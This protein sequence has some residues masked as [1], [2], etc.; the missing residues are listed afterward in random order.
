MTQAPSTARL[1]ERAG[2]WVG[3]LLFAGLLLCPVPGGMSSPAWRLS[4]VTVLMAVLWLTE[5]VPMAVT[6]LVPL[7]AFP[8]LGIQSSAVVSRGY[9]DQNV[10]L[11]MGGFIIALGIEKC[12]L[13]RR[14]ALRIVQFVGCGLRQ[15]VL[16][17]MLATGFLSMWISNTASTMLMFP[18]ALALAAAVGEMLEH[19][20]AGQTPGIEAAAN[21]PVLPE[22]RLRTLS[23]ALLL[24]IAYSASL[25]GLATTVGTPTNIAM[26]GIW[27]KQPELVAQYGGF[28]MGTWLVTFL[29]LAVLMTLTA[30]LV[31]TRGLSEPQ[32]ARK[33][34]NAFFAQRLAEL[35]PASPAERRMLVVFGITALLWILRSPLEFG[36]VRILPGWAPP[37]HQWIVEQLGVVDDYGTSPAVHDS[38]V[39]LLMAILLFVIPGA[40]M[41]DGR[42]GRLMDWE[43]VQHRLPWGILLLIGGG[44]V[45]A[46]GFESTGLS[47]WIGS[48]FVEHVRG[49]HPV[50]LVAVVCLLMTFLTEFTSNVATVSTLVPILLAASL[51]LGVDPRLVIVPATISA[52]C[53]FMLPIATPPNAIVFSSGQIPMREMMRQGVI[54]NLIGVVLVTAVTFLL[55]RPLMG[56]TL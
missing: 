24:G 49:W 34:G 25:G 44:L 11:Y 53:A 2:L 38:T 39:A 41:A 46:G 1:V 9:F 28:S 47:R 52:S 40:T 43:T 45:L 3:L 20:A 56:V 23:I 29:P 8:L 15:I 13:H 37:L 36:G 4:A 21:S 18:I 50:L 27:E 22:A 19:T 6:S 5:A 32:E 35:G 33:I 16:G 17:M 51:S 12:G 26:I 7:A 55:L 42:V 10:F 31:L 14:L 54:L 48:E 30:W